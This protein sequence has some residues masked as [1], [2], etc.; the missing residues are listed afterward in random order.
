MLVARNRHLGAIAMPAAVTRRL[1]ETLRVKAPAGMHAALQVVAATKH[2]TAAEMVRQV[3]LRHLDAEGVRLDADGTVR[4]RPARRPRPKPAFAPAA[5]RRSPSTRS[6]SWTVSRGKNCR[7]C[8]AIEAVRDRTKHPKP[9]GWTAPKPGEVPLKRCLAC[10]VQKVWAAFPAADA[11]VCRECVTAPTEPAREAEDKPE[12]TRPTEYSEAIGQTIAE[13]IATG[14]TLK[15]V[16]GDSSMPS[17]K[18]LS[19]WR[20][21]QPA[22]AAMLTQ[23]REA[24]ADIRADRVDEYVGMVRN[25]KLDA[26]SAGDDR[27][28][29]APG[30]G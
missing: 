16:S 26:N 28:R 9:E 13:R 12:A 10:Q 25:G 23:A 30:A 5:S 3:L 29:V 27:R 20:L 2:Q 4:T 11:E 21:A 15:S 6:M 7:E 19:R 14:E 8:V 22:F 18:T 17:E 24:R 1:P